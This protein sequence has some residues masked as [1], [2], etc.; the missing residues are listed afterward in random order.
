MCIRERKEDKKIDTSNYTLAKILYSHWDSLDEFFNGKTKSKGLF[1]CF[2][3]YD[4]INRSHTEIP[5]RF[6]S[7]APHMTNQANNA[8]NS[9]LLDHGESINLTD[10]ATQRYL[11]QLTAPPSYNTISACPTELASKKQMFVWSQQSAAALER[12]IL[13]KVKPYSWA[14]CGFSACP[15]AWTWGCTW[16]R[17]CPC[18]RR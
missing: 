1:D 6:I 17:L 3:S 2:N 12:E 16:S 7:F 14:Y 5:Y 11:F 13:E 8:S 18:S 15:G 9:Y 4:P 10:H